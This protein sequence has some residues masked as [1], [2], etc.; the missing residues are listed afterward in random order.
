MSHWGWSIRTAGMLGKVGEEYSSLWEHNGQRLWGIYPVS[1][2]HANLCNCS[3]LHRDWL[4][5]YAPYFRATRR[6]IRGRS[7]CMSISQTLRPGCKHRPQ[8]AKLRSDPGALEFSTFTRHQR[9][10]CSNIQSEC[11]R[12]RGYIWPSESAAV[13]PVRFYLFLDRG[14]PGVELPPPGYNYVYL[15]VHK[16]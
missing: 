1:A 12:H 11:L 4:P 8:T 16:P 6:N 2:E 14:W 3:H 5:V 15:E 13:I 7:H 10:T 9:P